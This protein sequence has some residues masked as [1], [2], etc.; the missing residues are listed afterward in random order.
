MGTEVA[1]QVIHNENSGLQCYQKTSELVTQH[2][3]S[4][5]KKSA[6]FTSATTRM[7]WTCFQVFSVF[8]AEFVSNSDTE[9]KTGC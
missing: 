8:K 2:T 3:I 7:S 1:H 4:V 5:L 6:G 9:V